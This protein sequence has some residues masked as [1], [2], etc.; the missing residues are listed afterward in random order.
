MSDKPAQQNPERPEFWDQRFSASVT[1]WEAD[2]V[3][4]DFDAFLVGEE[5]DSHGRRALVP[6]CGSAREA[7]RLTQRGWQTTALDFSPAAIDKARALLGADW[8]GKLL[9]ADFFAF[10]AGPGFDLIY[11]RAFLCALPRRRWNDYAARMAVLIPSGG[12]LAGYFFHDE[13]LKGPPFGILP[14]QLDALLTPAF[15]R[16]LDRP[17]YDSQPIFAGRERWQVWQRR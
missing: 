11:E 8:P 17:V 6:G 13:T 7:V 5:G 16:L 14:T 12:R 3:P 1:P 4:A 9:C 10:D 2:A 15:Q